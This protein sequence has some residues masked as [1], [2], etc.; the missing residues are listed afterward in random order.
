MS[1]LFPS[2]TIFVNLGI[3]HIFLNVCVAMSNLY[4]P[5][6]IYVN[7][8]ILHLTIIVFVI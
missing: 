6:N 3:V 7:L 1:S 2:L 8:D 4:P 5:L